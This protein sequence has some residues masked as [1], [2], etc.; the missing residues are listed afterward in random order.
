M[1]LQHSIYYL[2]QGKL[3]LRMQHQGEKVKWNDKASIL[4]DNVTGEGVSV[5]TS[6]INNLHQYPMFASGS[7]IS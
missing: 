2:A 6:S 4:L 7:K 1:V 5:N 3:K